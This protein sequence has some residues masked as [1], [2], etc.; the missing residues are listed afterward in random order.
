MARKMALDEMISLD[1]M[2]TGEK[3]EGSEKN[4]SGEP[5]PLDKLYFLL[6]NSHILV[7]HGKPFST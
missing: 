3:P 7:M 2:I 5:E 4:E 6:D 1:E